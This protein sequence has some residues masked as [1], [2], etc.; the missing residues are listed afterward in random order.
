[1]PYIIDPYGRDYGI[2]FAGTELRGYGIHVLNPNGSPNTPNATWGDAKITYY[3]DP[4]T[5][6]S[7]AIQTKVEFRGDTAAGIDFSGD[8]QGYTFFNNG[9]SNQSVCTMGGTHNTSSNTGHF[10]YPTGNAG[11]SPSANDS[12]QGGESHDFLKGLTGSDTLIGNGGDD[13]IDGGEGNDY[14]DGGDGWDNL[15]GG[16][17]NDTIY[18]GSGDDVIYGGAGNDLLLGEDNDDYIDGEAGD[19]AIAGGKGNDT[20]L[21]GAGNDV[22]A[23]NDGDGQDFFFE[24]TADAGTDILAIQGAVDLYVLKIGEHLAVGTE[25]DQLAVIANWYTDPGMEGI[26]IGGTTY[27]SQY[28]ASLATELSAVATSSEQEG[29]LAE[30][31]KID[32][33]QLSDPTI[34]LLGVEANVDI[35]SA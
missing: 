27:K 32:F 2:R 28:V 18:G 23:W 20:I 30:I 8:L 17:G 4:S 6:D 35:I 11:G 31:S 33:S 34:E 26:Q 15:L 16:A 5:V 29:V 3:L 13:Y 9:T 14:I 24:Y 19:D 21:G 10:A 25:M 7:R 1:M 22:F 12:V